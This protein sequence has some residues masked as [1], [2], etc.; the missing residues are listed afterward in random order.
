MEMLQWVRSN[1]IPCTPGDFCTT[2]GIGKTTLRRYP[3]IAKLVNRHG[4]RS[5]AA[6]M[7]DGKTP[8]DGDP[9]RIVP[10]LRRL[11]K[12]IAAARSAIRES[13]ESLANALCEIDHLRKESRVLRTLVDAL[14]WKVTEYRPDLGSEID[15]LIKKH[16]GHDGPKEDFGAP[17]RLS[18]S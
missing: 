3:R 7:R 5:A 6:R 14:A 10:E 17:R 13:E 12:G 15:R 11:R 2:A 9:G 16:L 4:W 8:A 1:R 18:P